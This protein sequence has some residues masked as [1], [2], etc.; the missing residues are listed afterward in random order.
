MNLQSFS[1]ILPALTYSVLI[2]TIVLI[3]VATLYT[4]KWCRVLAGRNWWAFIFSGTTLY[5]ITIIVTITSISL[6]TFSG[7]M[8]MIPA[9]SWCAGGILMSLGIIGIYHENRKKIGGV[10]GIRIKNFQMEK[11]F[12]I[13]LLIWLTINISAWGE[14]GWGVGYDH[15]WG[16]LI[17]AG[18]GFCI[19]FIYHALLCY[20]IYKAKPFLYLSTL[21]VSM[22]M[23]TSANMYVTLINAGFWQ[24]FGVNL[25]F[26]CIVAFFFLFVSKKFTDIIKPEVPMLSKK[27]V[28]IPFREDILLLGACS[29][30]TGLLI[31]MFTP[32]I[33]MEKIRHIFKEFSAKNDVTR[34]CVMNDDGTIDPKRAITLLNTLDETESTV[35]IIKGF[36]MFSLSVADIY[37]NV[38]SKKLV[39][40]MFEDVINRMKGHIIGGAD[41]YEILRR[42]GFLL[43]MP[44]VDE[45]MKAEIVTELLFKRLLSS[46]LMECS[47]GTINNMKHIVTNMHISDD[48]RIDATGV[49]DGKTIKEVISAFSKTMEECYHLIKDDLGDRADTLFSKSFSGIL[50][51][52]GDLLH[53][54]N[55][56][57]C[58]PKDV[59]LYSGLRPGGTYIVEEVKPDKTFKLFKKITDSG[60]KGMC[61]SRMHPDIVKDKYGY[62]GNIRWLS[63]S[64]EKFAVN[65]SN[66][67][68]IAHVI[69]E[70]LKKGNGIIMLDGIEYMVINRDFQV[71]LRMIEDMNDMMMKK[72]AIMI[73]P[74]T[75]NVFSKKEMELLRRNTETVK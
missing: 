21:S 75:P 20:R 57:E 33:G 24:M 73:I 9:L 28:D 62:T 63:K 64:D 27:T 38:T 7:L 26:Y 52:Y 29:D 48:G 25:F 17:L 60:L 43:K 56:L 18:Q 59:N 66:M 40:E 31:S 68:M 67:V 22:F 41:G 53:E 34:H 42:H 1:E 8:N 23:T 11:I 55:I 46:L 58:I 3:T 71:V 16:F 49:G 61:I 35:A 74:I 14:R 6:R 37:S 50:K 39:R 12:I 10:R 51:M 45:N 36:L 32:M 65:P 2:L 70:F 54:Y 13:L 47:K 69:G 44:S 15:I 5:I 72:K 4:V 19:V 30:F